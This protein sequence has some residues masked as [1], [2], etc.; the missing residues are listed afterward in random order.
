MKNTLK[1]IALT[2]AA[3]PAVVLGFIAMGAAGAV[4]VTAMAALMIG[5]EVT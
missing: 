5:L 4:V 1:V 3:A 2:A